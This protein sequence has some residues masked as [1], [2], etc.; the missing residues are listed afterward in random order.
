MTGQGSSPT[1]SCASTGRS[2]CPASRQPRHPVGAAATRLDERAGADPDRAHHSR[3]IPDGR[4]RH[5]A[6]RPT[7]LTPHAPPHPTEMV[8]VRDAQR[9]V[10]GQFLALLAVTETHLDVRVRRRPIQL[11]PRVPRSRAAD[12]RHRAAGPVEG[13]HC[14]SRCALAPQRHCSKECDRSTSD[15]A[16]DELTKNV[17]VSRVAGGLRGEVSEDPP[18][19][20]V[21]HVV[22]DMAQGVKVT[23]SE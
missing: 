11:D 5:V 19:V 16:I 9:D 4:L 23:G 18:Q 14:R 10:R 20:G 6:P 22:V 8:R 17:R 12:G 15:R 2:T 3:P 1:R 7:R 13:G 21:G